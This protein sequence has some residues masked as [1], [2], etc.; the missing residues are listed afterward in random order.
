MDNGILERLAM[1]N[2]LNPPKSD[3]VGHNQMYPFQKLVQPQLD[4]GEAEA[5]WAIRQL[6]QF[7]SP[8]EIDKLIRMIYSNSLNFRPKRSM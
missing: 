8:E 7:Y 6:S 3:S 1:I 5:E 2:K 4:N